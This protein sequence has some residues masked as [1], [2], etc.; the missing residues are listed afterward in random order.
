[1]VERGGMRLGF[2]SYNLV[3]PK[4]TWAGP[5]KP[6]GAYVYILTSY[7]LDHA[8]PGGTPNV[9]TGAEAETLERMC[10]D[11]RALRSETDFVMVSMH[12]GTVHTPAL[13]TAST[14]RSSRSRWKS[15]MA[16]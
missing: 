3:G 11:I 13:V 10:T 5:R 16:R 4:E 2:L 15:G 7:E 9:F 14:T 6:G 8:T 1:V 12:K